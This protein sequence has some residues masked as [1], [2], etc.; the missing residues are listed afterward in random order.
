MKT[1]LI[2]TRSDG[3]FRTL[4]FNEKTFYKSLLGFT[5]F[6]DYKTFN[7][8]HADNPGPYTG[9]KILKLSTIDKI[10]LKCDITDGSVLNGLGQTLL[11]S[12]CF[13]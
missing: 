7:A 12:F 11:F 13:K 9:D 4:R 6:L 3:M 8:I 1:K 5:Q 10:H 2:L